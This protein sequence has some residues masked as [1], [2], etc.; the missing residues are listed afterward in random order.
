MRD[1][2][3][4][5]CSER[6]RTRRR[7]VESLRRRSDRQVVRGLHWGYPIDQFLTLGWKVLFPLSLLNL[8][9][10]AGVVYYLGVG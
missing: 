10:T 3:R 7:F 6:I 9:V 4:E 5:R 1:P 2:Q 8:V